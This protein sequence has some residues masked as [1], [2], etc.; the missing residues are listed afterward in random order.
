MLELTV[1]FPEG[2]DEKKRVFIHGK[3]VNL[4][5]EHSL[6]SVAKWESKWCKC[7]LDDDTK[8][9]EETLDYI[10]CMTITKNVD[11]EV[12]NHLSRPNVE[13]IVAYMNHPMSATKLPKEKKI[14]I[15]NNESMT[16]EL[17][18]WQMVKREIP[19]ECQKWHLNRL[20][21]LLRVFDIKDTPVKK[22]STDEIRRSAR[23]INE[24]RKRELGS[25]G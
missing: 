23:E 7:Y 6:L 4:Q 5:L 24:A 3:T 16:S 10:K 21:T 15:I 13:A 17:I 14:G 20:I 19:M 18:Y 8:T 12:Y 1:S 22:R 2:W 9:N 11:P 25:K